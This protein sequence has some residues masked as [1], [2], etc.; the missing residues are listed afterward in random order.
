MAVEPPRRDS[1]TRPKPSDPIPTGPPTHTNL[2]FYLVSTCMLV[3]VRDRRNLSV[4]QTHVRGPCI[5]DASMYDTKGSKR[6][7]P[8]SGQRGFAAG[9]RNN[10][11]SEPN[12]LNLHPHHDPGTSP[13]VREV[14]THRSGIQALRFLINIE[15][16]SASHRCK[17]Q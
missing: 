15:T 7:N 16:I 2:H 13:G 6:S 1:I 3:S 17:W 10:L 11:R 12:L 14:Q 4:E 9:H 5:W 8:V